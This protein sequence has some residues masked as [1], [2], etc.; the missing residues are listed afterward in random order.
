MT[1]RPSSPDLKTGPFNPASDEHF[2]REVV[3]STGVTYRVLNAHQ[4]RNLQTR[5][6]AYSNEL[7]KA[8]SLD[9]GMKLELLFSQKVLQVLSSESKLAEKKEE[10]LKR[11]SESKRLTPFHKAAQEN[12]AALEARKAAAEEATSAASKKVS[13]LEEEKK[14]LRLKLK[15][16]RQA[17]RD[18]GDTSALEETLKAAKRRRKETAGTFHSLSSEVEHLITEKNTL[19]ADCATLS[20]EKK[21]AKQ[22]LF[23]I[24]ALLRK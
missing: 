23:Q 9:E 17:E 7:S 20:A 21:N 18:F 1:F 6:T 10:V 16:A 11:T 8:D 3:S 22:S 2:S 15:T 13:K 4:Q 24:Q 12:L 14:D 5:I 19:R